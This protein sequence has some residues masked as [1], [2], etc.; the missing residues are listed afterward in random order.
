VQTQY[1][2]GVCAASSRITRSAPLRPGLPHRLVKSKR[3]AFDGDELSCGAKLI[4]S[5]PSS[6]SVRQVSGE[7][8]GCQ[9]TR[10]RSTPVRI[11]A[12]KDPGGFPADPGLASGRAALF[13]P[14]QSWLPVDASGMRKLQ[15]CARPLASEARLRPRD[16]SLECLGTPVTT[17]PHNGIAY[18]SAHVTG[19]G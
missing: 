1:V 12:N 3:I 19:E 18:L 16:H 2:S 14:R 10:H 9:G 15:S 7:R 13:A 11:N 6:T 4:S 8:M 17:F 5:Q